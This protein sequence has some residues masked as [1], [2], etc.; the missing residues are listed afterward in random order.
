MPLSTSARVSGS[1]AA[2]CRYVKSTSPSR[3]RAYSAAIGSFTLSSSSDS[4]PHV[5]DRDDLRPGALVVGVGERAAVAGGRLDEHLVPALHELARAR[6]GQRD[7]VLVGL[8]LLGD[9]DAQDA[10]TL[11]G[12]TPLRGRA[13]A[14]RASW[15]LRS[16]AAAHGSSTGQRTISTSSSSSG[17][18]LPGVD[19]LGEEEVHALAAEAGRRPERRELLPLAAGQAALLAQLPLRRLERLLARLA[20]PRGQLDQPLARRLA[21]LANEPDVLV[22]RRPRGSRRRPDARR[23]RARSRPSARAS[24]R[25][26]C[27]R[28]R[29]RDSSGFILRAPRRARARQARTTAA[30]RRARSPPPARGGTSRGSRRRCARPRAP[31]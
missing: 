17:S 1:S 22:A 6:R 2:M 29:V 30:R 27:R 4:R 31:T 25:S 21:Q 14:R 19:A 13:G 12:G 28:R 3:R 23:S 8:D 24:R 16:R 9:A 7:A 5:V 18:A 20:C 10:R 26:A 15:R 11:A